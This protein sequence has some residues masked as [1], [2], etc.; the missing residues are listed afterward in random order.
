MQLFRFAD[1]YSED[2]RYV[3]QVKF[4]IDEN[5]NTILTAVP[6]SRGEFIFFHP[7]EELTLYYL[8]DD[9][10]Y[11][12]HV[13]FR[14]IKLIKNK[15]YYLFDVLSVESFENNRTEPRRYA[16]HQGIAQNNHQS[17]LVTVLDISDSGLKIESILPLSEK[18]VTVFFEKG[19]N[20]Y[21]ASGKIVW[22]KPHNGCFL[23]GVKTS[24]WVKIKR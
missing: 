15:I 7:T 1:M 14:E 11:T 3:S 5:D 12:Y 13:V 17:N 24:D 6:K 18:Y 22:E 10:I 2:H 4:I 21:S 23:Y 20:E 16:E 8:T 9:F 19:S